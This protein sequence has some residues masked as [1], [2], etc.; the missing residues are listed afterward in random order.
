MLERRSRKANACSRDADA[1]RPQRGERDLEAI[2]LLAQPVR[3]RHEGPLEDELGG[4]GVADPHLPFV[5][6]DPKPGR[7]ALDD[8]CRNGVAAPGAIDRREDDRHLR[9]LA[10]RDPDLAAGERVALI[11]PFGQQRQSRRV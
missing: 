8:E 9:L 6:G 2:P 5:P 7:V 10:V 1:S 3:F 11:G 4:N